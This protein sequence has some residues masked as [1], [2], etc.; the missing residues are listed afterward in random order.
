VKLHRFKRNQVPN[1]VVFSLVHYRYLTTLFLSLDGDWATHV[2][3]AVVDA[4]Y[5]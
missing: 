4:S 1:P 3:N 2:N 5:R